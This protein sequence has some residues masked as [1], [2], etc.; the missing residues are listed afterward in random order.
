VS[1]GRRIEIL[2]TVQGVG[3]RPWVHRIAR[4]MGVGGRVHND[5]EGV[6]IEAFGSPEALDELCETLGTRAPAPAAVRCLRWRPIEPEDPTEL[7]IVPSR[8]E[9]ERR[10]SIPPDL[11]TCA[12]CERE[13]GDPK[14]RR[15]R[16]A[17][18]N[19]TRC[20]PRFTIATGVPYDR[21]ATT[22]AS[23][24]MCADCAREYAD[25]DDRRFHAQPNACPRCG[26]RLSLLA[27]GGEPI[28]GDPVDQAAR[29]LRDGSIVAVKGLGGYHLACDATSAAAVAQLRARKHRDEKPFA[30]MVRDLAAARKVACIDR[31]TRALLRSP[32]RPI[33]V[34]RRRSDA[35]LAVA[36]APDTP[37]VGLFLP[38][39][40]LH[41]LLLAAVGRP[42]VMTSGN[43]AGEP[44]A[45]TESEAF[46]RLRGIA[47]AFL[48]HDRPI[49]NRCDDSV[50]RVIAGV[51]TLLR[52]SRGWVPS[53]VPLA[54]ALR[55]AV[56]GCGAH[57]KNTFC[58][59]RGDAAWLGPHV[60]DLE[61]LESYR[62]LG[63]AVAQLEGLLD[64][65]PDAVAHDLHPDYLSTR[66]AEARPEATKIAV[67]H[68]HAHVASAMA[69]HG[70]AGPVLGLAWDGTG[71]G[72]DGSA[73]GGELLLATY[74]DCRR[75]ATFRPIALAGGDKAIVDVWRL[76]LAA[77]DDA[78]DRS[79]PLDRI[80]LF[81]GIGGADVERVR[82]V[83]ASDAVVPAHGVGRWFD[84][85]GA[86][87][88]GRSRSL[89]EG[90]VA[91]AFA[92]A[93][94]GGG[95]AGSYSFT[96]RRR[97]APATVDL[98][99]LVRELVHDVLAGMATARIAQR[100]HNT[101]V[102]AGTALVLDAA[103][104]FG[105][106]PVVLTGGV[107]QNPLLAAGI[108]RALK[109]RL[110]VYRHASVPPGDG[111]IALGQAVVAAARLEKGD[112]PCA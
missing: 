79:P 22:M 37:N 60:G 109:P 32:Q 104:D 50:A 100:V 35:S 99:P 62:F 24:T 8:D 58:L 57:L 5:P 54:R 78:F 83:L 101:L 10:L 74:E 97:P 55:H 95:D 80:P 39:T 111:G 65:H 18:T 61:S 44:I 73:W 27:A 90:Q 31:E 36:V 91:T 52:R 108:E 94:A 14:N 20:G 42:L 4:S 28:A 89:H 2:G 19:C 103:P 47:D 71:L 16:Y 9:G 46:D 25:V 13:L 68:H 7:V 45:R 6:V 1:T 56:L 93:A 84:A 107:F 112:A 41:L 76:A 26:P 105:S 11:A 69:E 49:Q 82:E 77:L 88:L 110:R 81:R 40:P 34:C 17:F 15:H 53:A 98:R 12:A 51:P 92:E 63:E 64:F 43:R 72:P 87:A 21:A 70:L 59:A 75:L 86:I 23:F 29:L 3:F 33:V 38:Y 106:P 48:V 66:Y 67:Q 30:V 102:A 85:L 96:L